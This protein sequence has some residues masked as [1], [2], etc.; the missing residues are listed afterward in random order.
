[1]L[2]HLSSLQQAGDVGSYLGFLLVDATSWFV[3]ISGYLFYYIEQRRFDYRDYLVKKVKFVI[4][5]Y[6]I[7]SI[8]AL[9][10]GFYVSREQMV[11]LSPPMY[12]AW[13][14]AVGGSVVAPM[15]FIPMIVIFF[16]VSPV[17]HA[18]AKTKLVYMLAFVGLLVSLFS[19]RP[20]SS[21]NPLLTFVHF[22]GFY[23]LGM[24][25]AR[26]SWLV[27]ILR[28]GHW[29]HL[30]MVLGI[31]GF[32]LAIYLYDPKAVEPLGF[33]DGWGKLNLQQLGK[34]SLLV[35]V[36]LFFDRYL[37]RKQL[38]FGYLAKISFG[39]FFLHGFFALFF[40]RIAQ[41]VG[42]VNVFAAVM[43]EVIIVIGAA[44]ITVIVAKF[45]LKS[46]SRYVVGC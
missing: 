44:V 27:E 15:W 14:V 10:G 24:A 26:A 40:S 37:N 8:P 6:L 5:P 12:V 42:F 9:L 33:A 16:L 45:L 29:G 31:F 30:L 17:F 11:D 2:S 43:C 3:F 13:S 41:R 35:T 38:M 21:L 20:V 23:A 7:L 39:L 22:L 32:V 28:A 18:I 46:K 19:C 34:L 4:L 25:A 1:M 36:F